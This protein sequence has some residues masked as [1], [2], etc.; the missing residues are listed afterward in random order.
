MRRLATMHSATVLMTVLISVAP[1]M[2][3]TAQEAAPAPR[4][5]AEASKLFLPLVN[6]RENESTPQVIYEV[7]Y[8]EKTVV[9]DDQTISS[10][11]KSVS[12]DKA[13][14]RFDKSA[15]SA[16]QLQPGEIV[17]FSGLALRKVIGVSTTNNEIVVQ[18]EETTLNQ[19][20]QDGTIGW[21]LPV[22][23]MDLPESVYAA[24]TVGTGSAAFQMAEVHGFGANGQPVEDAAS[25]PYITYEGTIQGWDVSLK[26]T[27]G[28]DRLDID[29]SA[30]RSIG[31]GPAAAK[32][33]VSGKGWISS[34]VQ[35]TLLTYEEST[36]TSMSVKSLGL[37]GEMELEWAAVT[38][39]ED[40]LTEIAAFSIPAAIPIPIRA[41]PIPATLT[42]KANLQI[43]PELRVAQAS[44]GGS[45][46]FTY[47]SDQG[48]TTENNLVSSLGQLNTVDIGLSG[49]TGSAGWGPVGFGLGVEF[50]RLEL[51][52]LGIGMAFITVKSYATSIFLF[53]PPC[54]KGTALLFAKAG[55]KLSPLGFTV[56]EDQKEL[57]RQEFVKYKDDK[58]C[59]ATS[60]G[61]TG[62]P[63]ESASLIAP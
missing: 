36:P 2:Q 52:I 40:A 27:L 23:W 45:Y 43:V 9:I 18:T 17:L 47:N 48:F 37:D 46:K 39:G 22:N 12:D 10:N 30:S 63:A 25:P 29:L 24:T 50:P 1:A 21:T 19:A 4:P 3:A 7:A 6:G 28:S 33:S 11:L 62:L 44:S 49:D 8:T 5:E 31:S 20:I 61:I 38:P 51:S 16:A 34:F 41:G 57:W 13:E 56:A 59:E 15:T 42:I 14:Y 54:Q 32:A 60:A 35:E 55:Y 53:E 26:L 58:P